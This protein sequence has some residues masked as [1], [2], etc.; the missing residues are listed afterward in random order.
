MDA[1]L[2]E[3]KSSSGGVLDQGP[4]GRDGVRAR[5]NWHACR[6]FARMRSFAFFWSHFVRRLPFEGKFF[7]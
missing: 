6:R 1:P 3:A 2:I 5:L 7:L 4:S